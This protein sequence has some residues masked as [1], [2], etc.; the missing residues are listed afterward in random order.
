MSQK[1]IINT[2]VY[3]SKILLVRHTIRNENEVEFP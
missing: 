1:I 3:L 2:G